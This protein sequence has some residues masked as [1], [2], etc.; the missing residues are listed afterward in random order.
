LAALPL[1]YS[2][3]I[4][5][6]QIERR[7]RHAREVSGPPRNTMPRQKG[8]LILIDPSAHK[9]MTITLWETEADMLAS[10]QSPEFQ[11]ALAHHA[12]AAGD[13]TSEAFE[14]V[15][16][17]PRADVARVARVTSYQVE[18]GRVA[19]RLDHAAPP[20]RAWRTRLPRLI[21]DC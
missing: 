17:T 18:P 11:N 2:D 10:E 9:N 7:L 15:A 1:R 13:V 14:V 20:T 3:Q 6:G 4:R 8:R 12:H 5:P 21:L 16:H 19:E